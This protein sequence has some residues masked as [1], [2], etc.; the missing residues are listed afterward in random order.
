M[1]HI[2][3]C[4]LF[5][6]LFAAFAAA[7]DLT[8]TNVKILQDI[9]TGG[10]PNDEQLHTASEAIRQLTEQG[11]DAAVPELKKLLAVE[12]L[13][14]AVRTALVNIACKTAAQNTAA[15]FSAPAVIALRESLETLK[16]R[17]LAGVIE[18]LGNI[19]DTISVSRFVPLSKSEEETV[20]KAAI[21]ALGKIGNNNEA[22]FALQSILKEAHSKYRFDAA[23]ALLIAAERSLEEKN[24]GAALKI[25][26]QIRELKEF[27]GVQSTALRTYVLLTEDTSGL[28]LF[29]SLLKENDGSQR[30]TVLD[31]ANQ[32]KSPQTGRIILD[33]FDSLPREKKAELIEVIGIRKDRSVLDDLIKIAS[34][35]NRVMQ[36]AAVK[37]LGNIG[38]S[39][40]V[41]V[42]LSAMSF[43]ADTELSDA[44]KSSLAMLQG[45]EIDARIIKLL[46][47][48]P[49]TNVHIAALNVIGERRIQKAKDSLKM[50]LVYPENSIRI[51]AYRSFAQGMKTTPDDLELIL[52]QFVQ[53]PDASET[54]AL[55][56]AQ[57]EAL[58]IICVKI[59]NPNEA[60]SAVENVLDEEKKALSAVP[61]N[62]TFILELLFFIG[63]EKA[64][65]LVA[66]AAGE[67]QD[68]DAA[69]KATE[70]LGKWTTPE[71]APYLLDIAEKNPVEKYRIRALRGYVR[72]VRQLSGELPLEQRAAMMDKAESVAKRDED[73]KLVAEIKNRIQ[74]MLKGK[75][76][77]DGKTF[78]GWEFRNNEKSFRIEDGA[79]VA[80]SMKQ[81]NPQNEF[82]CTAKE[83]GDFTL[84]LEAKVIGG[85]ANAGVQ[86][87]SQ[88]EALDSKKPNEM[89]GYQADMTDTANFWGS[90]YDESRRNKFVAEA[91][92][93]EVKKIF[94]AGDWNELEIV[95]KGSNVKI[96]VNGRQTIDYTEPDASIKQ[97]GVI[98]L[99]IHSGPQSEAHYRN[100]RIEE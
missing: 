25:Y 76:L 21:L 77:F 59:T 53:T 78:D 61:S 68:A 39:K 24:S 96:F 1:K 4:T 9:F 88:R 72:I 49:H 20:A 65:K 17:N 56:K 43:S 84:R 3:L 91:D 5:V 40:A 45:E 54:E 31:L 92:I 97:S 62:R 51:I 94:R 86:I 69:D 27:P 37:A 85:G 93:N 2:V 35:N 36:V 98:G 29:V 81:N 12:E 100:I 16:G 79:I 74:M 82:I 60:V 80:G 23:N 46:N 18:S 67:T 41:D 42:L 90:L 48:T 64:G 95:C 11:T 10:K 30:K 32:L 87:R 7:D 15:M 70:L 6:C 8:Q 38:D 34:G 14:T 33:N 55:R 73:K 19:R 52:T 99:Q 47:N 66:D 57:M 13:N 50:F 22:F 26:E 71:V 58:K 44:G 63:G 89:I 75:L 83:Y 28:P